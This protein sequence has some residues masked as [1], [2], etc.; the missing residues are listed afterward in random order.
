MLLRINLIKNIYLKNTEKFY[1]HNK[2]NR[3]HF[4]KYLNVYFDLTNPPVYS[5]TN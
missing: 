4:G 5:N 2:M 1:S 3:K